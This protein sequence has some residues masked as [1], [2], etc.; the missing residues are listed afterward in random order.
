[1][2]FFCAYGG[3]HSKTPRPYNYI[4][5]DFKGFVPVDLIESP[6]RVHFVAYCQEETNINKR[7]KTDLYSLTHLFVYF[8][9]QK[10]NARMRA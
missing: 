5:S 9:E 8:R 3:E 1:M 4:N 6:R 7:H 2:L 10:K